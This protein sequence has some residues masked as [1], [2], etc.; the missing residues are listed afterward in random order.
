MRP[1]G[2]GSPLVGGKL[3][4]LWGKLKI[5][6][7]FITINQLPQIK[8]DLNNKSIVLVG[9][10]FDVLHPGHHN[11]LKAAEE[12]GDLL[13][14][15]L[16]SDS[17]VARRKGA[18]RPINTQLTRAE[19]LLSST[20]STLVILLPFPFKDM[21]YD[22]LV[23]SIKPAIIATT[24]GDQFIHHKIRQA[25]KIGAQVVEVINRL[26]K[27]STTQLINTL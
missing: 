13:V 6:K 17:A 10:C 2:I 26:P 16:E 5:V 27:Y 15:L 11:F 3:V 21:D 23:T 22:Q 19:N 9:G 7:T 12:K 1:Y 18:K 25:K 14:V 4:P 20:P 24:K 8:K